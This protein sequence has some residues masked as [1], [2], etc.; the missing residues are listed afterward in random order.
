MALFPKGME[1]QVPRSMTLRIGDIWL[2]VPIGP[3]VASVDMHTMTTSPT[4]HDQEKDVCSASKDRLIL[5]VPNSVMGSKRAGKNAIASDFVTSVPTSY[6]EGNVLG[7]GSLSHEQFKCQEKAIMWEKYG[8]PP[9]PYKG[10]KKTMDKL[11]FEKHVNGG[12]VIL[13]SSLFPHG[14]AEKMQNKV[15]FDCRKSF[16]ALVDES[17]GECSE[18]VHKFPFECKKV[19]PNY[20]VYEKGHVNPT[21]ALSNPLSSSTP[22]ACDFTNG[23]FDPVCHQHRER[24]V[25]HGKLRNIRVGKIRVQ[26]PRSVDKNHPDHLF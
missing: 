15:P 4:E 25:G 24:V 14:R 16:L 10:K 6:V 23:S 20:D 22:I 26:F 2:D 12:N 13:P 18:A 21:S 19:Y 7:V 9:L 11:H 3:C 8:I 5:L 17:N 1:G